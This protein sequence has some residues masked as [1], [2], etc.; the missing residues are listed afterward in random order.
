MASPAVSDEAVEHFLG[1][2]LR[3][4]V[5]VATALVLAG[6]AAHLIRYGTTY[7]SY[8]RFVGEPEDLS[9]PAGIVRA[10]LQGRGRGLIQFGLLV[11]VATPVLRVASSLVA[12]LLQR[13]RTYVG[14]TA[15]VLLL[16]LASL[17]GVG[18]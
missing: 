1:R 2:L 18:R 6:G 13:D 8:G 15:F 17:A 9:H 4:G 5:V 14:L 7:P 12:F 10:A 11:L 3:A 16:L